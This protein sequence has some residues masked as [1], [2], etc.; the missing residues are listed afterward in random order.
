MTNLF[1]IHRK[2]FK[3]RTLLDFQDLS[4]YDASLVEY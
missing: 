2:Y 4:Q 3:L 1:N